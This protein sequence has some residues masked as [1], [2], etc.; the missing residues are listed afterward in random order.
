M[1]SWLHYYRKSPIVREKYHVSCLLEGTTGHL[2]F[3]N[4]L[5]V[6]AGAGANDKHTNLLK[7]GYATG[8]I[9]GCERFSWM[10]SANLPG[11]VSLGV[12][13]GLVPLKH[14]NL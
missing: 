4:P 1:G 11:Q 7:S 2:G 13:G 3:P 9:K 10:T 5:K 12:H 8:M 14:Q 6:E